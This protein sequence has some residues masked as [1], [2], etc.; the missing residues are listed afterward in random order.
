[1]IKQ[2]IDNI[3][4]DFNQPEAQWHLH[5]CGA[6]EEHSRYMVEKNTVS[7]SDQKY[8]NGWDETCAMYEILDDSAEEKQLRSWLEANTVF[9]YTHDMFAVGMAY[10][11]NRVYITLR[12]R[13]V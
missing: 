1:M 5:M 10:K 2:L 7:M 13:N 6:C 11:N 12:G 4:E 3:R 9:L 8:R